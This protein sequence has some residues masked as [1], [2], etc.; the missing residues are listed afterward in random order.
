MFSINPKMT[1]RSKTEGHNPSGGR[2]RQEDARVLVSQAMAPA[3]FWSVPDQKDSRYGVGDT[4]TPPDHHPL[5]LWCRRHSRA[6]QTPS[7]FSIN[8]S[9]LFCGFLFH[10]PRH[11]Q[12]S[13]RSI[14]STLLVQISAWSSDLENSGRIYASSLT[15]KIILG[16]C[17][18]QA[19]LDSNRIQIR[20]EFATEKHISGPNLLMAVLF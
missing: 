18:I 6:H 19:C 5:T 3:L 16:G 13:P 12:Q 4:V 17:L 10:P 2:G 11:S 15:Q 8:P 1:S 7:M 20:F 9:L 14:T